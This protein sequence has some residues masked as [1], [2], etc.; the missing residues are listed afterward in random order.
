MKKR[1]DIF[2]QNLGIAQKMR[3]IIFI[4]SAV[5]LVVFL[6][7]FQSMIH[8]L[9]QSV[10]DQNRQI[11]SLICADLD[12]QLDAIQKTA[13]QIMSNDYVK[14]YIANPV[15]RNKKPLQAL[16]TRHASVFYGLNEGAAS[17]SDF[18]STHDVFNLSVIPGAMIVTENDYVCSD[19]LLSFRERE[20]IA[21]ILREHFV[22]EGK[23]ESITLPPELYEKTGGLFYAIPLYT[24]DSTY[25]SSARANGY[26][27]LF[28]T[29]YSVSR[30]MSRYQ[31]TDVF[32]QLTDHNGNVIWATAPGGAESAAHSADS[33]YDLLSVNHQETLVLYHALSRTDWTVSLQTPMSAVTAQLTKYWLLFCGAILVSFVAVLFMV[34]VFSRSITRRLTEMTDVINTVRKGNID[35]RY[36]VVYH[37]E[38]SL[39]GSEF[40]R[41]I[42][43]IQ[44]YHLRAA[45][46]ELRQREAELHALQSN[47]NP[48]FLYNSL[49]CI[50]ASA[51]TC[52]DMRTAH[53][54]QILANMFRYTVSTSAGR[55]DVVPIEAEMNHVYDYL[56]MLSFRFEDR[57][58]VD[59]RVANRI[60]SLYTPKLI[61]QP[62]IENA[63]RH[64]VRRMASGGCVR[65]SGDLDEA[66]SCVVFTVEDNGAGIP[67][68][69][70]RQLQSRL[71]STPLSVHD[72][73]FMGLVNI[74]D[75]IH[76][77]Y[78]SAYGVS[79]D[80]E[81]G[82]WTRVAVRIPIVERGCADC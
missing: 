46:Q 30:I 3:L 45:M 31:K 76:I 74:N 64:G 60:L 73:S 23:R 13:S 44:N 58:F 51:L 66:A 50:R 14:R 10:I 49:D 55:G 54:I 1:I 39:I 81:A 5:F 68:D 18:L 56:S 63:F 42:D 11:L 67:P 34:T 16:I 47:I 78:G 48:H 40:N 61:L 20:Q 24:S 75:R 7:V 82:S 6:T 57:Y 77:A 4:I 62:V 59:V 80:S 21:E 72:E 53:Q 19:N 37:D 36:P 8:D 35:C 71:A 69:R 41:M 52:G 43:Q 33:G 17:Y 28:T 32:I 27:F 22:S 70:L 2:F 9:Q 25:S 29:R 79:I 38:I 65:I 12:N 26:L 15:P